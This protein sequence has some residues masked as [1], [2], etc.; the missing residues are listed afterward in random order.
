MQNCEIR[1]TAKLS[2]MEVE[3]SLL[4]AMINYTMSTKLVEVEI[5]PG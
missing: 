3:I 4:Q 1:T 5:L 2:L